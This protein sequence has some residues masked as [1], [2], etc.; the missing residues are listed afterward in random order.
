MQL[1]NTQ[2]KENTTFLHNSTAQIANYSQTFTV[3]I[4]GL[5][6]AAHLTHTHSATHSRSSTHETTQLDWL[7]GM[8]LGG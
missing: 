4:E 2:R 6:I 5:C 1:Y 8:N 7:L 3:L